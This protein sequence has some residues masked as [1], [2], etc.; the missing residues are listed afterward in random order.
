MTD[1]E[2]IEI[3]DRHLPSQGEPFDTLAFGREV[4][5]RAVEDAVR[6][7]NSVPSHQWVKGSDQFGNP[8]MA[9]VSAT[10]ADYVAAMRGKK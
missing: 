6:A 7:V 1:E 2:I 10:R 3:R 4:A 8:C 5:A 9:K